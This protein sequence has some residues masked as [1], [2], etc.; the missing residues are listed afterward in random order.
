MSNDGMNTVLGVTSAI[1]EKQQQDQEA[2]NRQMATQARH[3]ASSRGR[4]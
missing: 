3:S 4:F 1:Q 2:M